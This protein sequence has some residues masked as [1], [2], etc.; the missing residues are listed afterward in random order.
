M[1]ISVPALSE[2]DIIEDLFSPH[3]AC[4]DVIALSFVRSPADVELCPQD[5]GRRRLSTAGHREVG[6]A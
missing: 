3:P 6:E 2:K 1:D 5:H 4:V